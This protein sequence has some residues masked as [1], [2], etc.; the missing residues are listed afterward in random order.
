MH[1]SQSEQVYTVGRNPDMSEVDLTRQGL[2]P[3]QLPAGA[4][5]LFAKAY[6]FRNIQSVVL[7]M[8]QGKCEVGK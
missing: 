3:A 5:L 2:D 8:K 4:R 7:K 6:G 1:P